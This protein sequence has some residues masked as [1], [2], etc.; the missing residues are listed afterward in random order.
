MTTKA[1]SIVKPAP[2]DSLEH[3]AYASV[4]N[5]PTVEPHD[6][7]RLGYNIWRWLK[8]RRDPLEFAVKTSGSRLLISEEETVRKVRENL[9]QLGVTE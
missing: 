8:Y 2:G 4:K 9:K 6:Q 3:I 7:D 1:P 5:I